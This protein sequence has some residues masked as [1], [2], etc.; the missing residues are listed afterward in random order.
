MPPESPTPRGLFEPWPWIV[1]GL[2]LSTIGVSLSFAYVA[3]SHRDALVVEDAYASGLEHNRRA[4]ARQ[5]ADGAGWRF[6][7]RAEPTPGGVRI[8][9]SA[10]DAAGAPLDPERLIVRR[11][12]PSEGGYDRDFPVPA[13][14]ALEL[15]LPRPGRWHLIARAERDGA[16]LERTYAVEARP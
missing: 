12:R 7:F 4:R 1:A 2:L 14:G 3:I 15:P 10:L 6:D 16:V 8:A 5:R 13:A 11:V 9:V